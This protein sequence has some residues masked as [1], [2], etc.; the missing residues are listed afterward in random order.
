[1]LPSF[2]LLH[3]GSA[4]RALQLKVV[5]AAQEQAQ[6]QLRRLQRQQEEQL[7]RPQPKFVLLSDTTNLVAIYE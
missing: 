4:L 1:M 7:N 2:R 5:V 6:F 3:A